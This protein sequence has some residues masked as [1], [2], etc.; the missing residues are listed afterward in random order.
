[1]TYHY[2]TYHAIYLDRRPLLLFLN[3]DSLDVLLL[4][5]MNDNGYHYFHCIFVLDYYHDCLWQEEV[6][7]DNH[8]FLMGHVVHD[9]A[10]AAHRNASRPY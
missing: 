2:V 10:A 9:V 4:L 7:E 3:L 6:E 1:M 8:S 5:M